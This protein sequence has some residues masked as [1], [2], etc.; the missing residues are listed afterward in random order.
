MISSTGNA[1]SA[2]S[3]VPARSLEDIRQSAR[4]PVVVFPECTTS[5]NRSLLRFADVF[6]GASVP[7]KG[8]SIFLMCVR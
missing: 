7:V 2:L 6:N 3:S 1:P 8:Y 4:R 5:N